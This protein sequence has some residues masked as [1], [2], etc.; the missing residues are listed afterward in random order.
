[1]SALRLVQRM[2]RDWI[3]TGRRP[4]GICG[5]ALLIAARVHGFRR[6]QREV[7]RVVR[8]CDMT[9]RK[10]LNEFSDTSLGALTARQIETVDLE[11]FGTP[12]DPPS[13]S[14]N[15]AID[16][17]QQRLLMEPGRAAASRG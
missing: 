3:Q 12:A 13:F 9:L 10:R 11:S 16:A 15:R 17:Q 7:V 5:A 1:M 2:K 4:S 8:I 6:T 14:R